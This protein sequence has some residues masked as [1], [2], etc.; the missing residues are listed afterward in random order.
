MDRL[1]FHV[2]VNNAFLSWEAVY[3]LK[4]NE[5]E[6]IR[7]IPS[8][9]GGDESA[10]RGIVLA[11]SIPAK[12]CGICT[13]ET[14]QSARTKCKEL[15]ILPTRFWLYS[16]CSKAMNDILSE[17]TP[18]IQKFS[19]DESFL[20]FSGMDCIR[21]YYM[22]LAKTIKERIKNELGFTVNIGISCNK[23]LAKVASDLKK[24]DRIHTL[25]PHEIEEKMWPLPV[26]DLFM[27][28]K[29]SAKKLNCMN[30]F[31]IGD[32]A[33][34]DP[35]LLKYNMKSYG[36]MIWRYANGIE[37]SEV[38]EEKTADMKS[39]GNSTTTAFDIKDSKMAK[40]VLLSLCE[41]VGAR[42]RNSGKYCRVVSL[43]IKG[44][45]MVVRSMQKKMDTSTD[46]T[47]RIYEE[48]CNLFD[49]LWKENP[50]RN[51]GVQV[52][53]LSCTGFVQLSMLDGFDYEKDKKINQAVDEIR[54]K[55]G[56]GSIVR[57][58]FLDSNLP[59]LFKETGRDEI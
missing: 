56:A 46:S 34:F 12:Q 25:F 6:D 7:N 22:K 16:K 51:L 39:I 49:K 54:L 33:K 26:E 35:E 15:L 37:Y 50:V 20:D 44:S 17:Y 14:L 59:P 31:T 52:S 29:T 53:E 48:V 36:E 58:C 40:T 8:V 55:Y 5:I 10:R 45:D 11:K 2:D 9:I 28:G 18:K 24:P 41:S 21:G 47:R 30:I 43:S 19:I 23:L 57:S 32:L 1:I 42:L 38:C 27:V 13:G 3:R 4:Q